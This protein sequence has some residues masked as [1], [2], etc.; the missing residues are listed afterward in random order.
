MKQ[1]DLE[2]MIQQILAT[3]K[4]Q[5]LTTL[6][7]RSLRVSNAETAPNE[8]LAQCR[9][10]LPA[11]IEFDKP[12]LSVRVGTISRYGIL[13]LSYRINPSELWNIEPGGENLAQALGLFQ[14]METMLEF[15]GGWEAEL[16]ENLRQG[17]AYARL[18]LKTWEQLTPEEREYRRKHGVSPDFF[19]QSYRVLDACL[20]NSDMVW[21][22]KHFYG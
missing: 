20:T 1:A 5:E 11:S 14:D 15:E 3:L 17:N 21:F 22:L 4:Y 9:N 19:I 12:A 6:I 10:V 18:F 2:L 8:V 13:D 16:W 7:G